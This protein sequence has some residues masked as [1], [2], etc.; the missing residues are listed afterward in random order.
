MTRSNRALAAAFALC[1]A[2]WPS[3]VLA[4]CSGP[5]SG[6]EGKRYAD[7]VFRGTVRQTTPLVLPPNQPI[8]TATGTDYPSRGIAF[9][10]AFDVSRV[11]KGVVGS[12]FALHQIL[13]SEDDAFDGFE[14]GTEYLVFARRNDPDKA[15][16]Y[17]VPAGTYGAHGCAAFD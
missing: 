12:Q 13:Q 10:V 3:A 15:A 5:H 17:G 16:L 6:M 4:D 11:W 9:T 14:R 2:A 7:L 8:V 1:V